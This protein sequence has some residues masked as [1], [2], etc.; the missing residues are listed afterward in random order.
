[1]EL[2][3][4]FLSP[5][6]D[7]WAVDYMPVQIDKNKTLFSLFISH[8]ILK[9]Q[10]ELNTISDVDTRSVNKLELKRSSIKYSPRWRKCN[11]GN[12]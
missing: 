11:S 6:K 4:K 5:T 10:A 8:R 1:M 7:I 3:F 2:V 9:T 12:G